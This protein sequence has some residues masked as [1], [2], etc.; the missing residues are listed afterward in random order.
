MFYQLLILSK[1]I[2]ELFEEL[3]AVYTE[4]KL[5]TYYI[6]LVELRII[7]IPIVFLNLNKCW[8]SN[9]IGHASMDI[10]SHSHLYP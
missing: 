6:E 10:L 3:I 8:N 9:F 1:F 2:T 7:F 5:N 4:T